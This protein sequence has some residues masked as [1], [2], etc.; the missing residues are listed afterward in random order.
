MIF[1]SQKMIKNRHEKNN[2]GPDC[3]LARR[4]NGG[5]GITKATDFTAANGRD[6][7]K[8]REQIFRY[9]EVTEAC[10]RVYFMPLEK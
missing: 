1:R 2:D 7:T 4:Y 9:Y 6:D 10:H 5:H 8:L 3:G